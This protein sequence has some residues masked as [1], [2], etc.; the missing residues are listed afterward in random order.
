MI[1]YDHIRSYMITYDH[2]RSYMIIYDHLWSYMIIYDQIWSYIIVYDHIWY[3]IIQDLIWSC[4]IIYNH[5]W[6]YIDR[7]WHQTGR[8]A[9]SRSQRPSR[10]R[11]PASWPALARGDDQYGVQGGQVELFCTILYSCVECMVRSDS[12]RTE[13]SGCWTREAQHVQAREST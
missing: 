9:G 8:G 5:I 2:I 6:S 13:N 10:H 7:S 1:I 11:A 4:M 3:M 12:W